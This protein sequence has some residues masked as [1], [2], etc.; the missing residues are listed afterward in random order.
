MP[1]SIEQ[2]ASIIALFAGIKV[3]FYDIAVFFIFF[4]PLLSVY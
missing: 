2:N 1:W 4:R 3:P